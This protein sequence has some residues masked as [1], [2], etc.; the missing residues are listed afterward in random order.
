MALPQRCCCVAVA[1]ADRRLREPV[2]V[3]LLVI[4]T[5]AII[6]FVSGVP[7]VV[8]YI[9]ALIPQVALMQ[10]VA[11]VPPLSKARPLRG[12]CCHPLPPVS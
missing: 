6:H 11:F 1:A 8:K 9:A 12:Q 5:Y 7:V 2:H 3:Q 4:G 10:G